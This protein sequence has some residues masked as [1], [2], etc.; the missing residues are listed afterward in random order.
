MTVIRGLFSPTAHS[1]CS[2]SRP[3]RASH[4]S[5]SG[6][7]ARGGSTHH[8]RLVGTSS[9]TRGDDPP[10][11]LRAI[12]ISRNA[13]SSE[14]AAVRQPT[15]YARTVVI[16]ATANTTRRVT[17]M[18]VRRAAP[19]LSVLAARHSHVQVRHSQCSRRAASSHQAHRRPIE[20]RTVVPTAP[21]TARRTD[22]T[23][24]RPLLPGGNRCAV[25]EPMRSL[26]E[27]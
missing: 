10:V 6:M 4:H 17:P 19:A 26:M 9:Y 27:S 15:M 2:C 5:I 11:E 18:P 23:S 25:R 7:R 12:H 8:T 21:P 24:L 14:M 1:G 3:L 16:A 20:L 22:L 13:R